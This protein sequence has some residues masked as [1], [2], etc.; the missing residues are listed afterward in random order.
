LHQFP[1][2]KLQQQ[3]PRAAEGTYIKWASDAVRDLAKKFDL[4]PMALALYRSPADR[5]E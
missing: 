4:L 2:V 1:P 3:T 5:R